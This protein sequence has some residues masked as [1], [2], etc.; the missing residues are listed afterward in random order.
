M[1]EKTVRRTSNSYYN[2]RVKKL[3]SE[4]CV[5]WPGS[6]KECVRCLRL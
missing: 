1:K 5:E 2:I 6:W 4:R 3:Q